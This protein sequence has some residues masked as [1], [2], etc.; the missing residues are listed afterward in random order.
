MKLN[1]IIR[2]YLYRENWYPLSS[3]RKS[4]SN[5][6]QDFRKVIEHYKNLFS[7]LSEKYELFVIFTSYS[8]TPEYIKQLIYEN[9][10][11]LYLIKEEN[12]NQFT[13]IC[14]YFKKYPTKNISI[15]IRSDLL[16]KPLLIELLYNYHY[17][18]DNK[19]VT[20][21]S[22]EPKT[23]LNDVLMIIPSSYISKM[24]ILLKNAKNAHFIYKNIK[25]KLL[26]KEKWLVT[27][28]NNYY[29]IFRG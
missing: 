4:H 1:I 25:I 10:W 24:I 13:S 29:E 18:N 26:T 16:L 20:I 14:S 28:K 23:K 11:N 15:V 17:N 21:L 19:N 12:S 8:N 3:A 2:G 5:Y 7:K 9:G 6:T 27:H 22:T